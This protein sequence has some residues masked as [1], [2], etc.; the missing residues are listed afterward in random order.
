[1]NRLHKNLVLNKE[2]HQ[3]T[4]R[5]ALKSS[6]AIKQ[7]AVKKEKHQSTPRNALKSSLAIKQEAV[8]AIGL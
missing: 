4:P 1:M 7:E 5:N 8:N 2:K 3:S 6:L